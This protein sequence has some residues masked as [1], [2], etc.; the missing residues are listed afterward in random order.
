MVLAMTSLYVSLVSGE[1]ITKRTTLN[2]QLQQII[3]T[4]LINGQNKTFS[5]FDR[6]MSPEDGTLLHTIK[7]GLRNFLFIYFLCKFVVSLLSP[8]I[9]CIWFCIGK[10]LITYACAA[11]STDCLSRPPI[12]KIF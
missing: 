1:G 8:Y 11:H 6:M 7:G 5:G 2:C 3:S 10:L 9:P 12:I 4:M